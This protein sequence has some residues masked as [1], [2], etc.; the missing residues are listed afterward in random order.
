MEE[1]NSSTQTE[2]WWFSTYGYI[3]M[4]PTCFP[5]TSDSSGTETA[6]TRTS[7]R[8][9]CVCQETTSTVILSVVFV[10]FGQC[11]WS[12]GAQ[13]PCDDMLHVSNSHYVPPLLPQSH[14]QLLHTKLT[15]HSC[16]MSQC[17]PALNEDRGHIK[18]SSENWCSYKGRL[19]LQS[20]VHATL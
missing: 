7:A 16:V 8:L 2:D 14:H 18:S 19:R 3:Y 17:E 12:S 5:D 1:C 9:V 20:S 15:M 13:A 10:N 11:G 6:C 4:W